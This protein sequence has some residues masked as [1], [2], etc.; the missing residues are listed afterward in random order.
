[1]PKS[2]VLTLIKKFAE[3]LDPTKEDK[4]KDKDIVLFINEIRDENVEAVKKLGKI[5]KKKLK[6]AVIRDSRLPS[7]KENG[8]S[9]VDL[10]ID[11]DLYKP[12]KIAEALA[13][14]QERIM[15]VSCREERQILNFAKVIYYIAKILYLIQA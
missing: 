3:E 11:C 14:Y 2:N 9:N 1:M 4:N 12:L 5:L 13:K 8:N 7:L 15:V 6:L 10:Y